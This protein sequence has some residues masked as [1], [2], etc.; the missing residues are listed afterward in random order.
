M[1]SGCFFIYCLDQNLFNLLLLPLMFYLDLLYFKV[2]FCTITC[3]NLILCPFMYL[4]FFVHLCTFKLFY[5]LYELLFYLINFIY[6]NCTC[7]FLYLCLRHLLEGKIIKFWY[8]SICLCNFYVHL[9][10]FINFCVVEYISL[11]ICNIS[12]IVPMCNFIN[13][14][15]FF[16]MMY[17]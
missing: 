12:F 4:S 5:Y 7:T 2:L 13:F 15:H 14:F 6:S 9:M 17:T 8:F 1:H 16:C 10:Y 11:S 3:F